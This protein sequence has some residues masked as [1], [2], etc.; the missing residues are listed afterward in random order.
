M[1]IS[2]QGALRGAVRP[3]VESVPPAVSSAGKEAADL[4]AAAGLV[5]DPWQ[6]YALDASLGE[7]AD[8]KWSA[9]EVAW[10]VSRQNGKGALLEARE[11]AGLFLFGEELI[12]HSAHEFKTAQEAF[13]RVLG[14]VQGSDFLSKQVAR[15][16][17][18]HGEEGIELRNGSRL[19]FVARSG[20]SGRGFT[21]DTLILDEAMILGG[22]VMAALLPT[23]SARPNPQVIYAASAGM[24]TSDQLQRVRKRGLAGGDPGLCYLEW[25]ADPAGLDLD[26][27]AGW[28]QA[29]PAMGIR[30]TEEFV[31]RERAAMPERE[32]ARE[33]LGVWDEIGGVSV[34][35]A[36]TW[37]GAADPLSQPVDPVA[38]AFD[39]APDRGRASIGIAGRTAA[40]ETH[41]E[42]VDAHEGTGW[43]RPRLLDLV[44]RWNPVSVVVDGKGPAASLIP[45]LEAEGVPLVITGAQDMA[46]ACAQFFDATVQGRLRHIDQVVLNAALAGA[47]KRPLGD[48]WAWHRQNAASDITPLVAV[49]LAL[50]GHGQASVRKP[51][52]GR[53]V[54]F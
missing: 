7:R 54:F 29:N 1:T 24:A 10:I 39:V 35:P 36:H 28:A 43:L 30:I 34:I 31:R 47:R 42:V 11:L 49:T 22:E 32:F 45:Q 26:D 41:V 33:R 21:G 25:S 16:R 2:T 50:F 9:F 46:Q 52:S 53:A 23:L 12:L 15:V 40:G 8:G 27:P 3:R 6:R 17:T 14:L 19:R 48:A 13:R 38:F 51:K 20:G 18:S 44:A 4:A 37:I 5:L